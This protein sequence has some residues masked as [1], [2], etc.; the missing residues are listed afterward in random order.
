MVSDVCPPNSTIG[1]YFLNMAP[2]NPVSLCVAD[3]ALFLI[4][5]V[6][7]LTLPVEVLMF[8]SYSPALLCSRTV[9]FLLLESLPWIAEP[10]VVVLFLSLLSTSSMSVEPT[11]P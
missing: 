7:W 11:R 10:T 1:L 8:R 2:S 6:F 9:S 5:E 4:F 3:F